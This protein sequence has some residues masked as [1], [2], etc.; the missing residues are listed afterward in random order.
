MCVAIELYRA[1]IGLYKCSGHREI[2]TN[3]FNHVVLIS[4][5]LTFGLISWFLFLIYM[6]G[7][8]ELNPGPDSSIK[9]LLLNARSVKSINR[10]RNKLVELQS[11]VILNN[12]KLVCLTETWLNSTVSD[13]EVLSPIALMST[14][15][16]DTVSVVV[17]SWLCTLPSHPYIDLT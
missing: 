8:V 4:Y 10:A 11:L 17:S 16:T 15:R 1:R 13:N 5:M 14:E 12:I 3:L 9:G 7:D 6:S 2:M